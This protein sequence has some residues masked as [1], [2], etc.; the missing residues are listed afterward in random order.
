MPAKWAVTVQPPP[1][2][3][4]AETSLRGASEGNKDGAD[5]IMLDNMSVEEKLQ[6]VAM[7]RA[8]KRS[9]GPPRR[10]LRRAAASPSAGFFDHKKNICGWLL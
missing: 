3:Q 9:A 5:I 10:S 6:A 4:A 2:N 8:H 1:V 7:V